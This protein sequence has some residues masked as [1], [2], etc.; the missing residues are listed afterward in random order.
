VTA[1]RPLASEAS[2]LPSFVIIGAA[3]AGT[4]ALYWYLAEHP[5][6]FMSPVKETNFFAY[7]LDDEGDTL[8]GDPDLHRFPVR[9]SAAYGELFSGAGEALAIGEASPIY[10]ECPQSAARIRETLPEARIICGLREPV[11]RAYSDYL[12]YLR[13]RGRRL[14]PARDLTASSDWARPDSHWMQISKYHEALSRYFD[15]FPRER[16]HI[17]LFDDF[18]S[19]VLGCVRDLYRAIGVYPGFV[20]DLDTPHNIGGMPANRTLEKVFTSG[21]VKKALEPWIPRRAADMARRLR[22]RNLRKAPPLPEGLKAELGLH[23]RDDIAM[24][25][26]LIGRNL[27]HWLSTP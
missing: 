13:A 15:R 14:D 1:A 19:D 24:T 22:T 21:S 6:V 27:D 12:M 20:P 2:A 9:T 23:F 18:R 25:S 4:T 26:E 16:I 5:Q 8:Y 3:K 10:L 7:G 17:F 11:D